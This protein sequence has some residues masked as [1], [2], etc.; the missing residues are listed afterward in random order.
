MVSFRLFNRL[1]LAG[2]SL[3][4]A[5]IYIVLSLLWGWKVDGIAPDKFDLIGA[6]FSE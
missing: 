2:C 1:I 5:G 4:T 6:G 3:H